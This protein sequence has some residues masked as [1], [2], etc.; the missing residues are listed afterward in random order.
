MR[1]EHA[2]ETLDDQSGDFL[3]VTGLEEQP[4]ISQVQAF[5]GHSFPPIARLRKN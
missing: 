3:N 1:I 4:V 5:S 2:Q